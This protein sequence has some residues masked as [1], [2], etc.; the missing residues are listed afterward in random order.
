MWRHHED[1]HDA[2]LHA[3]SLG[4]MLPEEEMTCDVV[5]K[6]NTTPGRT[7]A[8]LATCSLRRRGHR[9]ARQP[10]H[11]VVSVTTTPTGS[12]CNGHST[13]RTVP[14]SPSSTVRDMA[15]CRPCPWPSGRTHHMR[16]GVERERERSASILTIG[17]DHSHDLVDKLVRLYA[18]PRIAFLSGRLP[19]AKANFTFSL[20][21]DLKLWVLLAR[22][23][24]AP[25]PSFSSIPCPAYI[26]RE[27]KVGGW[28][29]DAARYG[30]A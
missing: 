14:A 21:L 10:P 18:C 23:P 26:G 11:I 16:R 13:D 17:E 8:A 15:S 4:D 9:P 12:G 6:T 2:G 25:S 5:M 22:S 3:G 29:L 27:A 7:P 19:R 24:S 30:A 28:N 20:R 1:K